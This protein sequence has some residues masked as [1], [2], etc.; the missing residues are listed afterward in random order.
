MKQGHIVLIPFPFTD[1]KGSKTRPALI[2]SNE[3][4]NKRKNIVLMAISTKPGQQYFTETLTQKDLTTG[5][6]KKDSFC[7]AQ[8]VFTLEKR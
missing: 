7:R 5:I 1:L 3:T 8:N 4:F 6:L 2:I